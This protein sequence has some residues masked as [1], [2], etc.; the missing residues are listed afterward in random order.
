MDKDRDEINRQ[1]K[2]IGFEPISRP[3]NGDGEDYTHSGADDLRADSYVRCLHSLDSI[4][5][6]EEDFLKEEN[7][8]LTTEE[9]ELF[10]KL[11]EWHRNLFVNFPG[12]WA[13]TEQ[14][15][16]DKIDLNRKNYV[17]NQWL[18]KCS[19]NAVVRNDEI[20]IYLWKESED[21]RSINLMSDEMY[22]SALSLVVFPL[23]AY[24]D[25]AAEFE[26]RAI[27]AFQKESINI[28][29]LEAKI[30]YSLEL[31]DIGV[32]V[33]QVWKRYLDD[34][35]EYIGMYRQSVMNTV[36]NN[37]KS[38]PDAMTP[39]P[40]PE[41][42]PDLAPPEPLPAP[43]PKP[44]RIRKATP[45]LDACLA[46]WRKQSGCQD[47]PP[48]TAIELLNVATVQQGVVGHPNLRVSGD[49]IEWTEKGSLEMKH[50]KAAFKSHFG[51]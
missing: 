33:H 4:A 28:G 2:A 46:V 9:G 30:K 16:Q 48:A 29:D 6:N 21:W 26:H 5:D 23:I 27:R 15:F 42:L 12:E 7:Y 10:G 14:I 34:K 50:F 22:L 35:K 37:K 38:E 8:K 19:L 40:P 36:F 51:R 3:V 39:P 18:I 20:A 25:M 32:L 44:Q 31:A 43:P 45:L 24:S 41:P 11:P 1:L 17:I 47:A 13:I 49:K